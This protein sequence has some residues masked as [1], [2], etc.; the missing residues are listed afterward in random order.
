VSQAPAR[1]SRESTRIHRSNLFTE[2]SSESFDSFAPAPSASGLAHLCRSRPRGSI[3]EQAKETKI[4]TD[5]FKP[6][7]PSFPFVENGSVI[8]VHLRDPRAIPLGFRVH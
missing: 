2:V 8:R 1:E 4:E 3:R 7:L 5:F 6:S